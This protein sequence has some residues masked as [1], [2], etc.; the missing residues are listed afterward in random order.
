MLTYAQ[1]TMKSSRLTSLVILP[2]LTL[3]LGLQLGQQFE[4]QSI[5]SNQQV[6]GTAVQAGSGT[7]ISNPEREADISQL[8]TV[9][10]LL[11]SR[12][13]HPEQLQTKKMVEGAI[14]GMVASIGDPYTLYMTPKENT[15]FKDILNGHLQGIGAALSMNDMQVVVDSV[16]KDS[17]A[18]KA[19]LMAKDIIA[20]VDGKTF[21]NMTLDQIVSMIRG[22]KGTTVTLT[23]IRAGDTKPRTF[24]IVRDDIK[25]PSTKYEVKTVGSSKIGVLTISEFGGNTISEVQD[26][27]NDID[28]KT[29]KGLIIDLRYN[30]GGYLEGA[31]SLSSIFLKQ[32]KVV[33]VAGRGDDTEMHSVSGHPILPGIPMVV[34]I[35]QGTASASEIFAGALKDYKRAEIVGMQSFGKGTV[36]EVLDLPG[37]SSLRVTI[38]RWLTPNGT[39]L[40]KVGITPDIVVERTADDLKNGTDAQMTAA[41]EFL[42]TGKVTS[43]KTGTGTTK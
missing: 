22:D 18:E 36:Q 12:Y 29:L 20:T 23:V 3:L 8:W 7:V 35:N 31:V 28:A 16:I 15:D 9:W 21:E 37:G 24:A 17:P 33:T 25:V 11:M 43:V 34:L 30:G 19:G 40:G 2:I 10:R 6:Q 38:A 13:V 39:D 4:R 42:T 26:I 14:R 1:Y 27:V 41:T 32:G 5:V